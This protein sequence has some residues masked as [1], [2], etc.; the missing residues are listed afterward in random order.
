M[1]ELKKL[2]YHQPEKDKR[3]ICEL[4]HVGNKNQHCHEMKSHG[5]STNQVNETTYLGDIIRDD[6]KNESNIKSRVNKGIGH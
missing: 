1:I 5:V 3:G 2:D 6:G 4:F